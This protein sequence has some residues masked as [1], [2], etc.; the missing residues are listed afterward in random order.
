[1]KPSTVT[2][3]MLGMKRKGMDHDEE[4]EKETRARFNEMSVDKDALSSDE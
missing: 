1:M 3:S 2:Q 4:E